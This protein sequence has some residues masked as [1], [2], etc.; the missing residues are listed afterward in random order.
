L[1]VLFNERSTRLAIASLIIFLFFFRAKWA[2]TLYG[3]Y[4][5][6][7]YMSWLYSLVGLHRGDCLS[8]S[9]FPGVAVVWL[10][11]GIAGRLF[12]SIIGGDPEIWIFPLVALTSFGCWVGALYRLDGEVRR[13][14]PQSSS[15]WLSLALL[16]N[17][18]VLYYA[19]HR[20][21]LSHAAEFILSLSVAVA[22]LRNQMAI[23]L[24]FALWLCATRINDFPI[25]FLVGARAYEI[26]QNF[27]PAMK[28][29]FWFLFSFAI[30]IVLT[31]LF[32]IAFIY[33]YNGTKLHFTSLY[34]PL[35]VPSAER[36]GHVLLGAD[37]GLVFTAPLWLFAFGSGLIFWRRLDLLSRASLLWMALEF[38]ICLR[39]QGNGRDFAY[40]YL[41]GS[42][43]GAFL[44]LKDLYRPKSL[45]APRGALGVIA[46]G[47]FWMTY[48][49]WIYKSRPEFFPRYFDWGFTL[50]NLQGDA[51]RALLSPQKLFGPIGLSPPG[52]TLFSWFGESRL[53]SPYHSLLVHA[54]RGSARIAITVFT[55]VSV[56]LLILLTA[57]I[58]RAKFFRR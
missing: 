41:I 2:F 21:M 51:V 16:L 7:C 34:T 47:A 50:P 31:S 39:W 28:R 42:Y 57:R 23:A 5:A 43:V 18:P 49:T 17:V 11:A 55:I 20:T 44:V 12:S 35:L 22:L 56:L 52:Y 58:G 9:Y 4:D 53:F 25:L 6:P 29:T 10:P 40:R 32:A 1:K 54:S 26:R 24:A 36:V 37:W 38:Y 19:T 46:A 14:F 45:W 48:L 13:R 33:G 8:N 30:A 15:Y 27:S 3:P